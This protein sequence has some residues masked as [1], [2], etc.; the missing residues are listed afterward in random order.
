[1]CGCGI[2]LLLLL[3]SSVF[4]S[5]AA[6]NAP[7]LQG[8][9][10]TIFSIDRDRRAV[11]LRVGEG[12]Y[13]TVEMH[14]HTAFRHDRG[15]VLT[16]ADLRVGDVVA[17]IGEQR[18]RY[19]LA[20]EVRLTSASPSE[21]GSERPTAAAPASVIEGTV[22]R[23][24][25]RITRKLGIHT[26][27]ENLDVDVPKDAVIIKEYKRISVHELAS[28]DR[29]RLQGRWDDKKRFRAERIYVAGKEDGRYTE[30]ALE[31]RHPGVRSMRIEG[32][33]LSHDAARTRLRISSG[34]REYII[35][36]EAARVTLGT[37]VVGR[38][39]LRQGDRVAATGRLRGSE[40]FAERIE[41]Q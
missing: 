41:I 31:D 14:T 30:E 13:V 6:Q 5:A 29:V 35:H 9:R 3:L 10:G 2:S 11:R 16:F 36:T 33:V 18:E 26:A 21:A 37:R 7:T 12:E 4:S 39:E 19:F 15:E 32:A 24:T 23:P 20:D 40:L 34:R 25:R 8:V 22:R 1:M 38:S 28:G 27:Q 17:A